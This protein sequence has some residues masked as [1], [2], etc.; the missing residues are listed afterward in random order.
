MHQLECSSPLKHKFESS[1]EYVSSTGKCSYCGNERILDRIPFYDYAD[2][3]FQYI[4]TYATFDELKKSK[5]DLNHKIL[6]NIIREKRWLTAH[7]GSIYSIL[8]P[9][10]DKLDLNKSLTESESFVIEVLGIDYETMKT[11]I[12]GSVLSY[13]IAL[14]EDKK[15]AY[16]AKSATEIGRHLSQKNSARAINRKTISKYIQSG[17]TYGGYKWVA[18]DS[19]I[20]E[21]YKMIDVKTL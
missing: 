16:F 2:R 9:H 14:D 10:N 1:I 7:E 13:V 4:K 12:I 20:Y 21:D 6:K 8:A 18:H 11:R 5:P 17:N 15:I 19:N 3:T